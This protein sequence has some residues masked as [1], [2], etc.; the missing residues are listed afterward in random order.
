MLQSVFVS[1]CNNNALQPSVTGT[2]VTERNYAIL[3]VLHNSVYVR[4]K[5]YASNKFENKNI[6]TRR[7]GAETF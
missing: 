3:Q 2:G 7:T 4:K 5:K 1:L 6:K